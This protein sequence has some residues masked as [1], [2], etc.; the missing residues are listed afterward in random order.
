MNALDRIQ[1]HLKEETKRALDAESR[2]AHLETRLRSQARA[3]C[4]A[5][6]LQALMNSNF[7]GDSSY[8]TFFNFSQPGQSGLW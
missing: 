7:R 5:A 2:I 1:L 4:D 3:E 6:A 8:I